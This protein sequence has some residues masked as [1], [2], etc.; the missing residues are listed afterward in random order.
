MKKI[1]NITRIDQK[2]H[3]DAIHRSLKKNND[4]FVIDHETNLILFSIS[5]FE[6]PCQHFCGQI[7][8]TNYIKSRESFVP[9]VEITV[10]MDSVSG[11]PDSAAMLLKH[12][13]ILVQVLNGPK[14]NKNLYNC[15]SNEYI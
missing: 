10:G 7:S 6:L 8:L 3:S 15:Y 9:P 14:T 11:K 12:E 13:D 1:L 2:E 4:N 5:P